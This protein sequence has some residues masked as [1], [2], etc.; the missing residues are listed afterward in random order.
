[1]IIRRLLITLSDEAVV[2]WQAY[3]V[4]NKIRNRDDALD[5]LIR[6][7]GGLAPAPKE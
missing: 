2:I 7:F 5:Q 6:E 1:M 4:R 3:Q